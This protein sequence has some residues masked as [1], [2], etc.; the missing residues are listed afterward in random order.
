VSKVS[1]IVC[2]ACGTA[3]PAYPP[4]KGWVEVV[5]LGS[6][7]QTRKADLCSD[8][9]LVAYIAAGSGNAYERIGRPAT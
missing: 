2:D 4:P 7:P 1:T 9:C 6:T 3:C 8:A 5:A